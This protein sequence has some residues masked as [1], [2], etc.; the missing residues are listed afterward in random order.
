MDAIEIC[1]KDGCNLR[2]IFTIKSKFVD[3][4][5]DKYGKDLICIQPCETDVELSCLLSSSLAA[6]VS[7]SFDNSYLSM[8]RTSYPS[9]LTEYLNSSKYI[10]VYGPEVS[11]AVQIMKEYNLDAVLSVRDKKALAQHFYSAV[12]E[13]F[14]LNSSYKKA[15]MMEHG[16]TNFREVVLSVI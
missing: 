11:T 15:L 12:R 7:Y 5:Q 4:L 10:I 1:N 6:F 8:V 16:L 13:R 9:K 3:S 2:L 14:D